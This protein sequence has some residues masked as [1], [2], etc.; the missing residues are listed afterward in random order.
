[1]DKETRNAALAA[2]CIMATFGLIAF[3]MPNIM[4]A[5]GEFST[6]AAGVI[7]VSFVAAF[8]ILFWL[9]GKSRGG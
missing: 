6:A 3:Y 4:L 7:A 9:R 2:T 5:V 8:F 1:M